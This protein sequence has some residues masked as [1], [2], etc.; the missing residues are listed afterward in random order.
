MARPVLAGTSAQAV[1]TPPM[2][3]MALVRLD[4]DLIYAD[5]FED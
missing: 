2:T 3:D 5:R 1:A 4:V